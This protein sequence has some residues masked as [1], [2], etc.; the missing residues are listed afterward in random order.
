M[1][2][3]YI[4]S[5]ALVLSSCATAYQKE[6]ATGGYTETQLDTN[7]FQVTFSGNGYTARQRATDFAL[8]RSA[9]LTLENGY[10]YFVIIDANQY[11]KN[12]SYT[13][14]TTTYGSAT[15]YGNTAYG[16]ATT[17]GGQTYH[18]SKPRASNTIVCFKEKPEG[19]SYNA[20][21]IENSLKEKYQLNKPNKEN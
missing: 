1:R 7:V 15:A 9:E 6:G 4:L 13:T 5:L 14:P 8:L 21:F 2:F 18:I 16:S 11:S 19:F 10:N 20:N 3:I 17:Y 12:S